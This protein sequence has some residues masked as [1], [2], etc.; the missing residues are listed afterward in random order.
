MVDMIRL[1]A[2]VVG[3]VL[4]AIAIWHPAPRAPAATVPSV[5][6]HHS[7]PPKRA[8]HR[9]TPTVQAAI[10]Y[11]VGAV[12]H[13]G[14]YR[15]AP[16]AR[17][18]D[19]V[20]AAGGMLVGADPTGVDLAAHVADGD[21]VDVP[22]L[23]EVLARSKSSR[24]TATHPRTRTSASK[25]KNLPSVPVNVNLADATALATV[26]GIGPAIA[27]RIVALRKREGPYASFDELLDVAGMSPARLARATP[28]LALH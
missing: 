14:L 17:I 22:R 4:A 20:R 15:V 21:E 18:N 1:G 12:A 10:I 7:A 19:A 11:V 27:Q 2:L 5:L 23:G 8:P 9:V 25:S 3:L 13:P 28:Y 24:R 16:T 26:P 6:A